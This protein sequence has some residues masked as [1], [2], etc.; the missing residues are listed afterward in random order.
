MI[1]PGAAEALLGNAVLRDQGFLNRMLIAWPESRIG[2][3]FL[4]E[5]ADPSQKSQ[6][7]RQEAADLAAFDARITALLEMA[8][9]TAEGDQRELQPRLLRLMTEARDILIAFFNACEHE[10]RDGGALEAIRGFA[11]KAPE[12]AARIAGVMAVFED[13]DSPAISGTTMAAA[14]RLMSWYIGEAQRVLDTGEIAPA[15]QQA[16]APRQWI[17]ERSGRKV[18]AV[19]TV[20]RYG[21]NAIRDSQLAR[22]LIKILEE[23]GWLIPI[24]G[25]AVIDGVKSK[26]AWRVVN[27]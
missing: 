18:I 14:T 2:T 20:T 11:A 3:R 13:P 8:P 17:V 9:P 21:P 6:A 19:R 1:Q 23:H 15:M 12:Q 27:P 22:R 25:G 4:P 24:D 7:S 10:M 26:A 5:G 16:E